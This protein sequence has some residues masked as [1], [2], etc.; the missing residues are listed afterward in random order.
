[1]VFV[2]CHSMER[3]AGV[4]RAVDLPVEEGELR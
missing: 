3:V 1:M 2:L 4:F